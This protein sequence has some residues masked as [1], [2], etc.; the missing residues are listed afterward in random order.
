MTG[1]FHGHRASPDHQNALECDYDGQLDWQEG[2]GSRPLL[3]GS[4]GQER[5]GG[6][7]CSIYE[8]KKEE[9]PDV[10]ETAIPN[11]KQSYPRAASLPQTGPSLVSRRILCKRI[12]YISTPLPPYFPLPQYKIRSLLH[13]A[14]I[15][16]LPFSTDPL[17]LRSVHCQR[18]AG[19]HSLI[20]S[21][22]LFST[23]AT[24]SISTNYQNSLCKANNIL[25]HT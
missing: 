7:R 6:E 21:L 24:R 3:N 15:G 25:H 8:W 4:P 10:S 12:V 18:S 9:N 16:L 14:S 17:S 20:H 22:S 23:T 19:R 1:P 5:D 2:G 13:S 11:Q